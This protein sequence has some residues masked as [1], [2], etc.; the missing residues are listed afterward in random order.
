MD[1]FKTAPDF[2]TSIGN[3]GELRNPNPVAA[4]K[5]WS[6]LGMLCFSYKHMILHRSIS[7]SKN[8]Y[9]IIIMCLECLFDKSVRLLKIYL[10][11][12]LP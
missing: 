2:S 1:D 8:V 9:L 6:S 4:T 12:F 11:S 7:S 10:S 3:L 5:L